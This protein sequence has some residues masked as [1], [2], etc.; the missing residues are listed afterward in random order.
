MGTVMFYHLTRSSVEETLMTILPRALSQG[1][2]VMLRGTDPAAL[3]RLDARLWLAE[4]HP[5]LPHG[6]EGGPHDAH[7]P[8]LIG[9]GPITNGAQG[10]FLID[11]A[12]TTPDEARPLDR[13]WLLFDGGDGAQ[14]A[15]A[16]AKWKS[17]TEAGLPAQYWSEESGRW[18]K[19]AER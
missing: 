2:R 17:L 12:A 19:K 11:G 5:F 18:E 13:V 14:L 8:V 10:L 9:R 7:Q 6:L 16:R 4:D 15:D 1:W 3:D